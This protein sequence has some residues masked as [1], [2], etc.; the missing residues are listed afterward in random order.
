MKVALWLVDDYQSAWLRCKDTST[1]QY[2]VS[3]PVCKLGDTLSV[4]T[5]SGCE[6]LLI[7]FE[8]DFDW[9]VRGLKQPV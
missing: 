7:L 3:L 1:D 4:A 9:E 2:R 5:V 6:E 8:G